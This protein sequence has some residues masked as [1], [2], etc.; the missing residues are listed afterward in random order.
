M[1]VMTVDSSAIMT[2]AATFSFLPDRIKA[3]WNSAYQSSELTERDVGTTGH[4]MEFFY[5]YSSAKSTLSNYLVGTEKPFR[6]AQGAVAQFEH[7]LS[8]ASVA[9]DSAE[10]DVLDLVT[11]LPQ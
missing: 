7:A 3:M 10:Q 11:K 2:D 8:D 4:L 6:G 9:Y 1:D 5:E